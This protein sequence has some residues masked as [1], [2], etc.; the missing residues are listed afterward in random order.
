MLRTTVGILLAVLVAGTYAF[1][2]Q[3]PGPNQM[4]RI[5]TLYALAGEGRFSIET[6]GGNTMDFGTYDGRPYSDKP[7]GLTYLAL[8]AY[9]LTLGAQRATRHP[10]PADSSLYAALWTTTLSTTVLLSALGVLALW[11]LLLSLCD[12]P[13]EALLGTLAC[14]FG[15]LAL[16]YGST[17]FSHTPVIGLLCIAM[18]AILL[19][20]GTA[21][22]HSTGMMWW[23][24]GTWLGGIAALLL[25]LWTGLKLSGIDAGLPV[26]VLLLATLGL[27]AL[28]LLASGTWTMTTGHGGAAGLRRR[29]ALAGVALGIAVLCEFMAA[30]PALALWIV[31]L[32][33][34]SRRALRAAGWAAL[35]LLLLPLT[36][37]LCFGSPFR[38]GYSTNAFAWM[39]SGFFGITLLPNPYALLLLLFSGNKGLLFWSP[40]L[41][42]AIP[43]FQ[44][45]Y[46]RH[47]TLCLAIGISS[48]LLLLAIAT[49]GNPGGGWAVGPRYLAPMIPLL[50]VPMTFGLRTL[51]RFGAGL[52]ALSIGLNLLAAVVNPLPP[53]EIGVP[54]TQFYL[55]MLAVG[56]VQPN[57]GSY[58]GLS[59]LAGLLPPTCFAAALG[60]VIWPLAGR[61]PRKR[62]GNSPP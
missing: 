58:L 3:S 61:L 59:P 54:L 34:D 38:L 41:V 13:R 42:L 19:P 21:R 8:P 9:T 45:L 1:I 48:A 37:W 49:T 53:P 6:L 62:T 57:A 24:A 20:T 43:G 33:R 28:I 25:T 4:S 16:P 26:A 11:T 12:R 56:R 44:E 31:L 10:P 30:F 5:D 23:R 32:T 17:L 15:T 50:I 18:A 52:I 51:P 47:R 40:C 22:P 46:A 2:G 14:W 29:D 7:P 36:N 55:P 35:P 27:S 39:R 60:I